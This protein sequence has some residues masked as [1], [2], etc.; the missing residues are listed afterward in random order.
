MELDKVE[1]LWLEVSA[2]CGCGEP[3]AR[4]EQVGFEPTAKELLCLWCLADL[5]AGRPRPARRAPRPDTSGAVAGAAALPAPAPSM[6][7]DPW[8]GTSVPAM[9]ADP[10]AA[11]PAPAMPEDPWARPVA[12]DPAGSPTAYLP[13][14]QRRSGPGTAST[15]IVAVLLVALAV[16]GI[17]R[18]IARGAAVNGTG[19]GAQSAF[20]DIAMGAPITPVA[21][22][23]SGLA[24]PPVPA[25]ARS[26]RLSPSPTKRS[27]STAY[28]FLRTTASGLPVAFDPCRPIHLV[29]NTDESPRGGEELIKEAAAEVSAATGL[30]LTVDGRTTEAPTI[31]RPSIDEKLYGNR[32]APVLVAWTHDSANA[33]LVGPVVGIG[34]P[35][36]APYRSAADMHYVTG[37]V[38]LDAPAFDHI[39]DEPDGRVIAR[40]IVMHEL[41]HLVG[42][43]H[44][45]DQRQ[46]MFASM[47]GQTGFGDGDLEGL[48]QV[49]SGPCFNG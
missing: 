49:G 6:P 30:V 43:G 3:L 4:G 22:S 47:V 33:E 34:G 41:G 39:L 15:L 14:R 17:P 38:L 23:G 45:A 24:E 5:R 1:L 35:A 7:S 25:D 16:L 10:W 19:P 42:L 8:A 12:Q 32:W 36:M 20:G 46:L 2:Q 26:T 31:S 48:R 21:P 29:V 18:L 28:T 44:V 37:T 40:S 11:S 9:P 27:S 13:P